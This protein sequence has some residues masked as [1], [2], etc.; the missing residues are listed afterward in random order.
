MEIS[1]KS[2]KI[3]QVQQRQAISTERSNKKADGAESSTLAR[4]DRVDVSNEAVRLAAV[5]KVIDVVTDTPEI[6]RNKVTA[7]REA[8]AKGEYSPSAKDVASK[9]I[10]EDA[11]I[12]ALSK[13]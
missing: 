11:F 3:S 6:D 7:L 12:S 9:M 10:D 5:S 1:D 13:E 8:I 4:A 2:Q